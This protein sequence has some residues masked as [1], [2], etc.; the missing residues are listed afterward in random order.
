MFTTDQIAFYQEQGYV[1]AKNV[2]DQREL[3]TLRSAVASVLDGAHGLTAHTPVYDLEPS[4]T[5]ELPRVRRI[6][7]PHKHFP[8]FREFVQNPKIVALLQQLLGPSVRLHNSKINIK[9]PRGGAAVEWHQDWAFYPHTNDDVLAV[10]VMLDDCLMENGPLM[11]LPRTHKGSIYDHHVDGYFAGAMDLSDSAV[12]ASE[13]VALVAPAG[14]LS[15]HHARTLHASA[16]NTSDRSRW[17]LL[18]EFAAA[19]AWPLA[20]V[21]NLEEFNAR[22]ICGAPTI[23]PRLTSVPVRLPLPPALHQGSIY[24]NQTALRRKPSGPINPLVAST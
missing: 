16:E 22:L 14:S 9:A 20:G 15:F 11:I 2:L 4:H 23:E 7:T 21:P 19:D 18:Y 13:A 5:A 12:D 1:V 10:G 6:K 8:L 3:A 24:E 17:L